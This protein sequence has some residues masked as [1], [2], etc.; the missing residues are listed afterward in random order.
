MD[1]NNNILPGPHIY[2]N[3]IYEPVIYNKSN[4]ITDGYDSIYGYEKNIPKGCVY[5]HKELLYNLDNHILQYNIRKINI[6]RYVAYEPFKEIKSFNPN[7]DLN[8]IDNQ[9]YL[10]KFDI[11]TGGYN[12]Q[13]ELRGS[14]R[15][16]KMKSINSSKFG[17]DRF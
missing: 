7:K 4:D 16:T 11:N 14:V 12:N 9:K 17:Y 15:D 6:N 13:R 8:S 5:P 1:K 2:S 3:I 10:G